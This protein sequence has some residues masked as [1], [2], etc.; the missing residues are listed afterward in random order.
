LA[1][2]DTLFSHHELI[3]FISTYG[4][5]VIVLVIGF[6]C[7]GLPLPGETILI[8][9]AIYAGR[10]QNLN[11]W[12][13]ISAAALGAILGNTAGFWVGREGGYRLL[14]RYGPRL[15]LT[16]KRIK[17][18]QYLFLRHGGKIVFFSR[19]IAVIR[20]FG[21]LLAGANRMTW[22]PFQLFNIAGAVAWAILY[23]AGAYYLGRKMHLFTRYAGIGAGLTALVLIA[24]VVIYLRQHEAQLQS[25][26]ERELPGPL[27][28][29]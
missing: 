22:L 2:L 25:E 1:R 11:I 9:A 5:G 28:A 16:E 29:P 23:G 17:L 6:E 19:F 8:A 10:S 4:Y 12:L 26:A 18:G 14:L 20:V 13:V 24:A 27:K 15:H 7:L 3:H 21:A